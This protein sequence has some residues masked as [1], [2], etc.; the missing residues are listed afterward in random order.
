MADNMDE[1]EPITLQQDEGAPTSVE[2]STYIFYK[3]T[4][5]VPRKISVSMFLFFVVCVFLPTH[6]I[7]GWICLALMIALLNFGLQDIPIDGIYICTPEKEWVKMYLQVGRANW[8]LRKEEVLKTR[9]VVKYTKVLLLISDKEGNILNLRT[10]NNHLNL[11]CV[12]TPSHGLYLDRLTL[13]N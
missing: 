13:E 11:K 2:A 6:P 8:V 1:G 5:R 4:K 7:V 3:L 12:G 9:L 10:Y